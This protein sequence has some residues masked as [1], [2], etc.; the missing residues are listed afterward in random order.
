[1]PG[2]YEYSF[3]ETLKAVNRSLTPAQRKRKTKPVNWLYPI[4]VE[5]K[6]YKLILETVRNPLVNFTEK[7]L[8][9]NLD[10][11][12]NNKKL[13]D[14]ADSIDPDARVDSWIDDFELFIKQLR[15]ESEKITGEEKQSTDSAWKIL[16]AAF[17]ALYIFNKKQFNK[18]TQSILGFPFQ[19]QDPWLN[20]MKKAWE[21]ENYSLIKG[22]SDDYINQINKT[23][24][25]GFRSGLSNKEVMK[26]IRLID[27]NIFGP[28]YKI[29]PKTGKRKRVQSRAEL[30]A[31][32][33]IGKLNG[34]LT[35]R[36]MEDIGQD[37]YEWNTAYDERVRGRPGG[38]YPKAI[39]SHWLMQGKLC[40]WSDNSVYAEKPA[41]GQ[42]IVWLQREG[43]MPIAIPGS[44]VQCRCT[45]TTWWGDFFE[46]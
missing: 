28:R 16:A 40:K 32:D 43:K 27:K 26:Q 45:A 21:A 39:P 23:A 10:R 14:V 37:I 31:R 33:Q 41:A 18:T 11:L 3:K 25:N 35:K 36:H 1:M 9:E 8:R 15:G 19:T 30:L 20:E 6:Y 22:L 5:K 44:E 13:N 12:L 38:K 7:W 34:E 24:W 42:K 2:Q 4:A 46:D 29:D 17:A